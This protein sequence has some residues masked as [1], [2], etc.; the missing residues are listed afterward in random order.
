MLSELDHVAEVP[1]A[2]GDIVVHM[3]LGWARTL[4][5]LCALT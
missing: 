2:T 3:L 5:H 1:P 4:T